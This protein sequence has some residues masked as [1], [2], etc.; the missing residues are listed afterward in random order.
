MGRLSYYMQAVPFST[1]VEGRLVLH[2][3]TIN[4]ARGG[5]SGVKRMGMTVENPRKLP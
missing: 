2:R 3:P 4:K 5:Y 1:F